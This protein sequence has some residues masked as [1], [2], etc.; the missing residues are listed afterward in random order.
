[1]INSFPTIVIFIHS[2]PVTL[3]SSPYSEVIQP[4][5]NLRTFSL[6][7]YPVYKYFPLF[8]YNSTTYVLCSLLK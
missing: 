6:A 1:M 8:D 5:Y 7:S 2:V 4:C 3:A